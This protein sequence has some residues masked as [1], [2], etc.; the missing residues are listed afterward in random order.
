MKKFTKAGILIAVL[1][2]P[3]LLFYWA[4][5]SITNHYKLPTYF[6]MIDSTTNEI[7]LVKNQDR[8]G[9]EP[10]M[11]TVFHQV[12]QFTLTD[13]DGKDFSSEK[14]KGK[15]FVADFFFTRCGSIC[16]K[17]SSQLIRIQDI[18][19]NNLDVQ[20]V[21]FSVDPTHDTPE[22]LVKYAKEYDAKASQWTFLTGSRKTIYPLAVKGFFLPVA[23]ASEY[24]KAVKTPDETFIHSEKLILVDKNKHIRGF[25]DGTDRKD[26]DRLIAEIKVL[27]EIHKTEGE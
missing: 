12:P 24:D 17:M 3:A 14:L 21:S 23:D 15:V 18:F 6:P 25:Y 11:D 1:V 5:G 26:V 8:K 22:E 13:Q 27:L 16:P 20:L 9:K 10:E 4:S 7:L 2:I 19:T